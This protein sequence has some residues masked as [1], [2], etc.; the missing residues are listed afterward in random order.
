[1]I[2]EATLQVRMQR[3]IKTDVEELYER[4][5]T[6][7]AEAVRIFA[8]QSLV[9]GGMPFVVQLKPETGHSTF[10]VAHKYASAA[11]RAL[12]DQGGAWRRAA[13]RKRGAHA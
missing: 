3:N 11:G 5:G 1:M 2:K 9:V 13:Q 7:F 10:G 4:L 8:K 6:S 12:E